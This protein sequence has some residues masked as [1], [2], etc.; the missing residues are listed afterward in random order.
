MWLIVGSVPSDSFRGTVNMLDLQ[1]GT[2]GAWE[3]KPLL[4]TTNEGAPR[5][6]S[7]FNEGKNE[8]LDE[9]RQGGWKLELENRGKATLNSRTKRGRRHYLTLRKRRGERVKEG[10]GG[11]PSVFWVPK[12]V[13]GGS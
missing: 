11:E 8:V 4:T 6:S 9:E 2:L 13:T 10:R 1:R 7:S 12:G 5:G 3:G